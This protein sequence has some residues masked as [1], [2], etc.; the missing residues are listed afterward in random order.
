MFKVQFSAG[1]GSLRFG[2]FRFDPTLLRK[3]NLHLASIAK[4][5]VVGRYVYG[6][7]FLRL[8]PNISNPS[9]T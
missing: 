6:I 1:S 5:I 8:P 9:G 7:S 3:D 4:K 2:I